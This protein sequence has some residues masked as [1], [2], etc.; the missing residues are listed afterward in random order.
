M[1]KKIIF[2]ILIFFSLPIYSK[3]ILPNVEGY[4]RLEDDE[5]VFI[6]EGLLFS[7]PFYINDYEIEYECDSEFTKV[8]ISFIFSNFKTKKRIDYINEKTGKREVKIP[9]TGEL[10]FSNVL[11]FYKDRNHITE[12]KVLE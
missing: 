12:L 9:R 11:F 4:I 7:A 10:K 5:I 6:L 8:Y 1:I 2:F 3:N